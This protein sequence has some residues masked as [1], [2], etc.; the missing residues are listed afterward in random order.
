MKEASQLEPAVS[1]HMQANGRCRHITLIDPGKQDLDTAA[2]RAMSAVQAG[3]ECIFIGGST[4]TSNEVVHATCE[5]IKEAFEL[6]KFAASQ[7]L[8]SNE[9]DWNVPMIL[10]PGGGHALSSAAD[11]ILFMMLMNSKDR[12][13]LVGEQV[14]GA[15]FIEKFGINTL[16]T[17][18]IVC[19][20][21]GEVGRVGNV[22]LIGKEDVELVRNYALTAKMYGFQYLYLEAGSGA[23]YQVNIELIKAAKSVEGLTVIVG[24]GIRSSEQAIIAKQGGADWI[25]TGTLTEE[26]EDYVQL[27]SKLNEI[28]SNLN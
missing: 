23:S 3:S 2:K 16:P 26:I 25:V 8:D 7:D 15:P 18:Y 10:F 13:F 17:G 5:A 19:A 1:K 14:I 28:I 24:G 4:N 20:P 9:D 11:G 6:R 27:E 21:G 12:K 22:D